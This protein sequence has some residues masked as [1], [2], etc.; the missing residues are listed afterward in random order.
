MKMTRPQK[1]FNVF[2][3]CLLTLLCVTT[4]YPFVYVLAYSFNDSIDTM[5]GG[6]WLLPRIWTL[7][8]YAAVLK[9]D[10]IVNSFLIS[11]SKTAIGT[12]IPIL[13]CAMLS[14]ALSD[15]Q[16]PGRRRTWW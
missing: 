1:A 5:R 4:L 8:N 7:D 14:Y 6:L 2:N 15:R 10:N 9:D 11:V 3:V 16:L 13:M 12:T